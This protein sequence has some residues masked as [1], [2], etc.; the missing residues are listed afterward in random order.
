M[1]R[2][3]TQRTRTWTAATA[4]S[5]PHEPRPRVDG[6]GLSPLEQSG[7]GPRTDPVPHDVGR[8]RPKTLGRTGR[9]RRNAA[10]HHLRLAPTA[11][12]RPAA[13]PRSPTPLGRTVA[14]ETD[15]D[16]PRHYEQTLPDGRSI[17]Y[18]YDGR[19][20]L[21]ALTPP[22]RDAHVFEY[23]GLD[24]RTDY[25]PP[26]LDGTETITRYTY[27]LD[28][29]ITRDPDARAARRSRSTTTA[30]GALATRRMPVGDTS[31]RLRLRHR[32]A[33]P[34]SAARAASGLQFELR[35]LPARSGRRG[36]DRSSG[37]VE[38]GFDNNFWLTQ[39]TVNGILSPSITTTTAC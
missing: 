13:W 9:R 12:T 19:G 30:A 16:W 5:R 31:L 32:P 36:R 33:R 26:D 1:R 4:P 10:R 20:N 37:T 34:R 17:G 29:Q 3:S 24:Q 21:L 39:E 18:Q 11:A 22:G 25:T 28:R 8:G 15:A 38:R 7:A 23:D 14:F 6:Q 27:N 35:W 2:P